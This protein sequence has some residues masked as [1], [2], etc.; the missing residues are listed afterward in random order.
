MFYLL[1]IDLLL[2]RLVYLS[3]DP[4]IE[5][6][7]HVYIHTKIDIHK[8]VVY[9]RAGRVIMGSLHAYRDAPTDTHAIHSRARTRI[10]A[11][12][13]YA[14]MHVARTYGCIFL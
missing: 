2:S 4:S 9:A 8:F 14:W 12:C 7:M 1:S 5:L 3:I 10:D 11:E 6:S 13:G